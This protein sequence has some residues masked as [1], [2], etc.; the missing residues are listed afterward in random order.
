MLI[1]VVAQVKVVVLSV[2]VPR[3][4]DLDRAAKAVRVAKG[5]VKVRTAIKP[6]KSITASLLLSA[7]APKPLEMGLNGAHQK[8]E[9]L[10]IKALESRVILAK[11]SDF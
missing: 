10:S 4:A 9:N 8:A 5:K 7:Q 6:K 2:A 11:A 1:L 3:V